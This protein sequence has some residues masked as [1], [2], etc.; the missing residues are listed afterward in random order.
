MGIRRGFL[1]LFTKTSFLWE[2][3]SCGIA[4]KAGYRDGWITNYKPGCGLVLPPNIISNKLIINYGAAADLPF[5]CALCS[6]IHAVLLIEC[7]VI[8]WLQH[9]TF[10][11][12]QSSFEVPT[13]PWFCST[14]KHLSA[15]K[16]LLQLPCS[17]WAVVFNYFH[18]WREKSLGSPSTL[19]T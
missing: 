3:V 17:R 18:K 19:L 6:Q 12:F 9:V 10:S 7:W 2:K 8:G 1:R 5:Q 16:L 11:R 15:W 4:W 14:Y 13:S